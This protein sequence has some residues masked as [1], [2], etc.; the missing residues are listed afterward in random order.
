MRIRELAKELCESNPELD[1]K[2]LNADILKFLQEN[3][4]EATSVSSGISDEEV[5]SV[6]AHF[7]GKSG[8]SANTDKKQTN[9]VKNDAS[10]DEKK[11][12]AEEAKKAVIDDVKKANAAA[13]NVGEL[14][15]SESAGERP[16]QNEK[17]A[18]DASGKVLKGKLRG[19]GGQVIVYR[20]DDNSGRLINDES[21]EM[22]PLIMGA[23]GN[24]YR[25][26]G[27]PLAKSGSREAQHKP[28]PQQPS[29]QVFDGRSAKDKKN[30]G[31]SSGNK[32][33]GNGGNNNNRNQNQQKGALTNA[34]GEKMK[35]FESQLDPNNENYV[36]EK[37]EKKKKVY[38]L[39]E[40]PETRKTAAE[41]EDTT[42]NAEA[43]NAD[44]SAKT[45]TAA[46]E[47]GVS[48]QPE[49]TEKVHAEPVKEKE[50]PVQTENRDDRNSR[51]RQNDNRS[52]DGRQQDRPDRNPS[53]DN[54]GQNMRG[55]D[56]ARSYD[57]RSQGG[58]DQRGDQKNDGRSGESGRY[59]NDRSGDRNRFGDRDQRDQRGRDGR[60]GRDG[61]QDG[62][63]G[64]SGRFNNDRNGDRNRFGD[65]DQRD[66][67]GRD[68]SKPF[69]D[70]N[71]GGADKDSDQRRTFTR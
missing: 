25:L 17:K 43:G 40:M 5:D 64:D 3:G 11:K 6:R 1:T 42:V 56:G 34:L 70:R 18:Q 69:G 4:S 68:G 13:N 32:N 45:E 22:L 24:I 52:G 31:A 61:R 29:R 50:T 36:P 54:N 53:R 35:A 9:D 59:N 66:Q 60:D 71:Q 49:N 30:A 39:P 19:K 33:Q 7:G 21:G 23:D 15:S 65:R 55:R 62:R 44:I 58:R 37:K 63:G 47:T 8:K 46:V 14:K 27:T 48:V 41:T 20:V 57:G 67:R 28:A 51:N 10:S 2:T 12:L 26:D 16:T 38:D